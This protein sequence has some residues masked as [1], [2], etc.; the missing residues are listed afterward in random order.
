LKKK[1]ENEDETKMKTKT[2]TLDRENLCGCRKMRDKRVSQGQ[3]H[4]D[5]AIL[6]HSGATMTGAFL[7]FSY[8]TVSF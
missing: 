1:D 5:G 2:K 4:F 6:H 8:R 7:D 3:F